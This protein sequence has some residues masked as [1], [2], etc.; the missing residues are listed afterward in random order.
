M[1]INVTG[2]LKYT[3]KVL[4]SCLLKEML[5]PSLYVTDRRD[6]TSTQEWKVRYCS[7]NTSLGDRKKL[8]NEIHLAL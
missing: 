3:L 8:N 2:N 1:S 6:S 5:S 4:Y 7:L